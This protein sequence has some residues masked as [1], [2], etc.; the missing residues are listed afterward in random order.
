MPG[1]RLW[2]LNGK[3]R[4]MCWSAFVD[5]QWKY[6]PQQHCT[7]SSVSSTDKGNKEYWLFAVTISDY[8]TDVGYVDINYDNEY[9]PFSKN[10]K[11]TAQFKNNFFKLWTFSSTRIFF[12]GGGGIISFNEPMYIRM[13]FLY[14]DK[15]CIL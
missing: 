1:V 5:S 14:I 3:C 11:S 8:C 9:S 2:D 4:D 13:C 15:Y 7:V 10:N 12:L 6:E